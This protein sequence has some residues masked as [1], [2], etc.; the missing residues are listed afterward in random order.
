LFSAITPNSLI[1]SIDSST[2]IPGY[3]GFDTKWKAGDDLSSSSSSSS[4]SNSSSSSIDSS[5]SSSSSS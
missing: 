2:N 5:S 3:D 4:L 1:R